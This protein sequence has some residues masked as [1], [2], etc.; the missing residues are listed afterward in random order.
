VPVEVTPEQARHALSALRDELQ[1]STRLAQAR[2]QLTRAELT[3]LGCTKDLVSASSALASLQERRLAN[4][5]GELA[6]QLREGEPCAVCGGVEHPAPATHADEPVTEDMLEA[7]RA[8]LADAGTCARAASDDVVALRTTIDGL[9]GVRPLDQLGPLVDQAE[10]DLAQALQTEQARAR[11]QAACE[12]IAT[13][14]KELDVRR[15]KLEQGLEHATEQIAS[16]T[17]TVQQARGE[18]GSV[19]ER[20]DIVTRHIGVTSDL[21]EALAAVSGAQRHSTEADMRFRE[22][23][24]HHGF[25][26]EPAFLAAGL[27]P[28][29]VRDLTARIEG[30]DRARAGTEAA[31]E[32]PDLQD[33][34]TEPADVDGPRAAH[35][36]AKEACDAASQHF[37][38]VRTR[39]ATSHQL[40][41]SIR[42]GWA[43]SARTRA[44]YEVL[45][46][47]ARSLHGES[48]NTKRMRL[49]SYV[50]AA[51]LDQIVEAA[52][53]RLHAMSSGR[54]A[55]RRSEE[56]A[57]RGS[58]AGLEVRVLDEYTS[59]T[60]PPE[61]LSGG[62]KF[63]ASLA[64]ALGLAEVVTNR[65]G[66]VT[67]D[68]L[69]IDEGFGSLDAETLDVAMHTLDSLRENGRT[70]GLI[71][72]VETM[73]ERIPA[74]LAVVRT[75]AG[76]SAVDVRI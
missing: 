52:N 22:A 50:L 11:A 55:L 17:A 29:A 66:G 62:E 19:V 28:G 33:L 9:E 72:H 23:L 27:E 38:A 74:Q 13:A 8:A 43:G 65:A 51:E 73:K 53:A 25:D 34:P 64:L 7:A 30:H 45:D 31:L 71:S 61:S 35:D 32:A 47:L 14:Q 67:L 46:R 26:D 76:C 59:Q 6:E 37:G 48:P 10:S 20:I 4:F 60:R 40:A 21:V 41:A 16:L 5:A 3:E 36:E 49:E 58:N 44:R 70:I 68:T 12:R 1:Q 2:Q 15:A 39:S 69:F 54:Y 56:V 75:T 42:Q 63:L 24:E 57:T 18:A